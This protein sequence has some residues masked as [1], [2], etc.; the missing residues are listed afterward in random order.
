MNAPLQRENLS[1]LQTKVWNNYPFYTFTEWCA[2]T[3]G[4][5][6]SLGYRTVCLTV[7]LYYG[8]FKKMMGSSQLLLYPSGMVFCTFPSRKSPSRFI[9]LLPSPTLLHLL[10]AGMLA[11]PPVLG[12]PNVFPPY[13]LSLLFCL[14]PLLHPHKNN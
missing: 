2:N 1:C 7:S 5:C 12:L 8:I 13:H 11:P 10:K 14:F 9:L 3:Q 6:Y 4:S